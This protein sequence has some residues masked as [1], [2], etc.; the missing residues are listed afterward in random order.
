MCNVGQA[1]IS[2]EAAAKN[3][4]RVLLQEAASMALTGGLP[5]SMFRCAALYDPERD[6]RLTSLASFQ[7]ARRAVVVIPDFIDRF[8]NGAGTRL[9][10]QFVY[11]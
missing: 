5:I 6:A 7:A 3:S 2:D 9:V 11:Q 10:L 4:V 1:I 8:G